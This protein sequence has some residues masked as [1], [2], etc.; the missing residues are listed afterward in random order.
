[1]PELFGI[2]DDIETDDVSALDVERGGLHH[3]VFLEADETGQSVDQ[4]LVED[5]RQLASALARQTD[6]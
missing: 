4:S 6:E 3:A 5:R 1:V 2:A